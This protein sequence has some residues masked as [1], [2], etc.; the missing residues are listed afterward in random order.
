MLPEPNL[1]FID[2]QDDSELEWLLCLASAL[3]AR[4]QQLAK[5]AAKR[6]PPPEPTLLQGLKAL[7]KG[8]RRPERIRAA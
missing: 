3:Q 6:Q 7:L 2:T 5:S 8:L 1:S 4:E